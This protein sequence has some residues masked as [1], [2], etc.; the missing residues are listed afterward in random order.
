MLVQVRCII[1]STQICADSSKADR[2][3][4]GVGTVYHLTT[5]GPPQGWRTAADCSCWP[6]WFCILVAMS[7]VTSAVEP[8]APQV[9]SQKTGPYATMRSSRSNRFSTPYGGSKD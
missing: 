8:P 4:D 5:V 6:T 7:S 2:Q 1:V 9:M 3:V